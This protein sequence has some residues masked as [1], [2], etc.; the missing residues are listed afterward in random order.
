M[1][2]ILLKNGT[3][4]SG[5]RI[6]KL[7]L[8]IEGEKIAAVQEYIGCEDA[9]VIDVSGK[10]LFPGFIDAHTHFKLEVANTVTADDFETGTRAA[11][12]GGTTMII[13]YATQYKGE[14]LSEA[15]EN[16]HKKA[17]G[18][19]SC[20]YGFHMA[21]SDWNEAV[22]QDMEHMFEKGVS[23]FKLYMTYPDMVVD[24]YTLF[25]VLKRLKKLG[26]IAG[27]H[28]ENGKLIDALI[29]VN[30]ADGLYGPEG[31]PLSRR[32]EI[33]AE[34][35][36]RLLTIA[37]LADV[38]VMVVH[39][40]SKKGYEVIRRARE[41]GQKVFAETCP[42]YLLLDDSVYKKSDFEGAKY[43]CSPPLRKKEDQQA[44]WGAVKADQITTMATDHCSF[45]FAQ[46]EAGRDDFTK[47]PNGMPGVETRGTLLYSY[48][49]GTGRI[50]LEQLCRLLSENAAKLYG[51]YPK[52]GALLPG[53]DADI[54]VLD[55][56]KEGIISA[57]TQHY[58]MDYS[59]F[60]GFA[61]KGMIEDVYLRG[62]RVVK[63]GEICKEKAGRY[64]KRGRC[65]L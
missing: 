52:K 64:V 35:I 34:A 55:P 1:R 41:N 11:I 10:L 5:S 19:A 50:S 13:D 9:E 23:T 58:N 51:I 6:E 15:L 48:G 29:E 60:E 57:K 43:I 14:L 18:A 61:I 33:E 12:A 38:P 21:I 22:S 25:H 63:A 46:K 56:E 37:R 42:Q 45:S 7:D 16:W 8:L 24:D 44:L 30:Q 53:S 27:V 36:N 3:V 32:D 39:L 2:K 62:E 40:S 4:V 49:Y 26:G 20:D 47:I 54:A 28:C 31:H 17:D 59:P 65:Q